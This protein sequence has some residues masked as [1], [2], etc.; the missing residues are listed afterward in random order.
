M[1]R[2][3]KSCLK[4]Q[5]T[6]RMRLSYKNY[7]LKTNQESPNL[8]KTESEVSE[9]TPSK[10]LCQPI[11]QSYSQKPICRYFQNGVYCPWGENCR[12]SHGEKDLRFS[13]TTL[14]ESESTT[15]C[16]FGR[17]CRKPDSPYIHIHGRVSFPLLS[18]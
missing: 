17:M 10:Q 3:K 5:S 7:G 18:Q 11:K 13:Q 12:Y 2:I 9:K 16:W 4:I 6:V 8:M 1:R 15:E 14:S